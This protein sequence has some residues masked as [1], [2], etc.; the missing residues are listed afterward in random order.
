MTPAAA[1]YEEQREDWEIGSSTSRA[2][3]PA[4]GHAMPR[5]GSVVSRS[6][7]R[8]RWRRCAVLGSLFVLAVYDRAQDRHRRHRANTHHAGSLARPPA[9]E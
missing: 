4:R 5:A 3:D 8:A 9:L 7:L 1:W 2:N 6:S